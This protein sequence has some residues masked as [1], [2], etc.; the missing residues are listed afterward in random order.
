MG[1]FEEGNTDT[2]RSHRKE[3]ASYIPAQ[4]AQRSAQ[5]ENTGQLIR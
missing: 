2:T 4:G 3:R 5:E 1:K